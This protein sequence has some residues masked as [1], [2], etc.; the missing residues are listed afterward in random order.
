MAR[1]SPLSASR[2][3]AIPRGPG[4]SE[5][6]LFCQFDTH[7]HAY[8][9]AHQGGEMAAVFGGD[10]LRASQ[11]S[12]LSDVR[13]VDSSARCTMACGRD[14]ELLS[15]LHRQAMDRETGEY[16]FP[17]EPQG[18]LWLEA[19]F[20]RQACCYR[21]ELEAAVPSGQRTLDSAVGDR[22]HEQL[23]VTRARAQLN[24]S[25]D[26]DAGVEED[27]P[28]AGHRSLSS[29]ISLATSISVRFASAAR[30]RATRRPPRSN[31]S[32]PA[33]ARLQRTA[34][35]SISRLSSVPGVRPRRLRTSAGITTRPALSMVAIMGEA[36]HAEASHDRPGQCPV[37]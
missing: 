18:D 1:N 16:L 24:H 27:A 10:K 19:V 15:A 13:I 33:T 5:P 3:V 20:L 14:H 11:A 29:S 36:Y 26:E 23:G 35:P 22:I 17:Q 32:G 25:G 21:I 9:V 6:E 8:A 2:P 34:K 7:Q 30:G 4:R 28:Q 31:N 12:D 37:A